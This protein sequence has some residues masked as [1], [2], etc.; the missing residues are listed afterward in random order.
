M[1]Y[2]NDHSFL[3]FFSDYLFSGYSGSPNSAASLLQP[4]LRAAAA[5]AAVASAAASDSRARQMVN[6]SRDLSSDSIGHN[7]DDET[8]LSGPED[9][10]G[11][12][13]DQN[14]SGDG[15]QKTRKKK[16]RTVFSR[17]QVSTIKSGS[18]RIRNEMKNS[19]YLP[20]ISTGIHIRHQTIFV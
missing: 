2:E 8:V 14:Q 4:H 6:V 20:G 5:A 19:M 12:N 16:T 13:T 11:N 15:K 7:S 10:D 18:Q 1:V 3:T 9:E 17:S